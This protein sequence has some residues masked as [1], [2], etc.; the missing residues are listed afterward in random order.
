MHNNYQE[1]GKLFTTFSFI[2]I[3]IEFLYKTFEMVNTLDIQ[4]I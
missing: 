1:L 3:D 4:S 2:T